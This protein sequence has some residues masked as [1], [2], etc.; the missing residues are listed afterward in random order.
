MV[1]LERN[2]VGGRNFQICCV[3]ARKG[4]IPQNRN[5]DAEKGHPPRSGRVLGYADRLSLNFL[6]GRRRQLLVL[7]GA[8]PKIG[9]IDS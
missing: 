2:R 1:E 5:R 6:E 9:P 7:V 8:I 4:A 3:I